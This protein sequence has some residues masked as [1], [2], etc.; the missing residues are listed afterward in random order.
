[1]FEFSSFVDDVDGFESLFDWSRYVWC[2]EVVDLD[3][4]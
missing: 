3:L 1:M 4:C 2:V